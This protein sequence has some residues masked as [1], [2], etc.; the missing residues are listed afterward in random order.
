MAIFSVFGIWVVMIAIK[1]LAVGN[2]KDKYFLEA[3]KEYI[4]RLSAF[5]KL[6]VKELKEQTHLGVEKLI[7]QKESEEIKKNLSGHVILLDV[8]GG[9]IS[10]EELSSE[11]SKLQ[12][13]GV[14]QITFVIGGSYGVSDEIKSIANLRLSFSKMT[15]PHGLFRVMLLE[16]VYRAFQIK[17]GTPYHK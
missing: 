8:A 16:Q 17:A 7:I 4:K 9:N 13:S 6:E 3:G 1:I 11:I 14:S 15:F 2:L 12:V 10:S 5:C